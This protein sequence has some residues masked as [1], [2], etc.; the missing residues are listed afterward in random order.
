M[1]L[2]QRTNAIERAVDPVPSVQGVFRPC[3]WI[4]H[5]SGITG[6]AETSSLAFALRLDSLS[7][8]S[9]IVE[10]SRGATCS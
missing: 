8:R 3:Q 10:C 2:R 9:A 1:I 4:V 6:T 5:R 7:R